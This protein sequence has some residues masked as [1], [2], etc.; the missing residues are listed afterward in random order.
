MLRLKSSH[1]PS[2]TGAEA[3]ILSHCSRQRLDN[4]A[5]FFSRLW[6]D[7]SLSNHSCT[8]QQSVPTWPPIVRTD[9]PSRHI[10][11]FTTSH[12]FLSSVVTVSHCNMLYRS[13]LAWGLVMT[14]VMADAAKKKSYSMSGEEL[15]SLSFRDFVMHAANLQRSITALL[16]RQGTRCL[17]RF[18]WY[19]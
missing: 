8:D 12:W 1:W 19:Y 9:Q 5:A 7:I 16:S 11:L 18:E 15:G 2:T 13:I 10:R 6:R 17:L 3:K 14:S 4:I